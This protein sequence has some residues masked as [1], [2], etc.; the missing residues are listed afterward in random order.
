MSTPREMRGDTDQYTGRA[1]GR[2]AVWT[3]R[4]SDKNL[5]RSGYT[6]HPEH[7]STWM[8]AGDNRG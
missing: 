5:R 7:P 3:K 8:A 4:R 1:E 2:R 6:K